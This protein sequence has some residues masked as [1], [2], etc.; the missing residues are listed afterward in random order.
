M[1]QKK[2]RAIVIGAG[3]A[4]LACALGLSSVCEAVYLVEKRA[5]FEKRGATF[6]LAKNGQRAV[7]EL[8]PELIECMKQVGLEGGSTLVFVWWEFRDAI[9]QSVRGQKNIKLY[10]GEEFISIDDGDDCAKVTFQSGL[11]LAADFVV[12]ADGVHS[13]VR[14]VL[15]LPPCI[16]SENTLF[17]GSLQVPETASAE[18]KECLE[19]NMVPLAIDE[20]GKV[21]FV[22]FNF[23]N[24]HPG[25]LAWVFSTSVDVENEGVTPFTLIEQYVKD[26]SKQQLIK[27]VLNLSDK[28]HLEPYPKTSIVDLSDDTLKSWVNCGFGGK[29]R[30]TL[31]GDAAHGMRPTDGYGGS[32]AMEDA[33][34]L[35]RILKENI[36]ANHGLSIQ[37]LL[38]KFESER[39]P[40]VKRVYDNQN[41]RYEMRMQQGK[42]PGKQ[43]P[44]FL[45]WLLAGV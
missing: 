20:I 34:V 37:H 6:G 9:L 13:H 29:G 35:T 43:D 36:H 5:S 2:R 3:P 12:G 10:C 7:E 11:E 14:N 18:L 38:L 30:I 45:E 31:V 28:A 24:R 23:H 22:L 15:G 26:E 41:E 16:Q 8:S 25:R 40:R 27:E 1:S 42:R 39:L 32:M 19:K 4:G 17:R 44:E 21:Y 33:V